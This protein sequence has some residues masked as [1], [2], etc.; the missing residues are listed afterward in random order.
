MGKFITMMS[1]VVMIGL[2]SSLAMAQSD[3]FVYKKDINQITIHVSYRLT[4]GSDRA[5]ETF[6]YEINKLFNKYEIVTIINKGW[7]PFYTKVI[8]KDQWRNHWTEG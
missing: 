5:C 1:I 7:I 8:H 3:Y 2:F 6:R 4:D